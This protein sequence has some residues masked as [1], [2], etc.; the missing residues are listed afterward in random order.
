MS[1]PG[2]CTTMLTL[3]FV[4]STSVGFSDDSGSVL[5]L[6]LIL[7]RLRQRD[8][9]IEGEQI[10]HRAIHQH[11]GTVGLQRVKF[12]LGGIAIPTRI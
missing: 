3:P 5:S 12:G 9:G 7:L 10:L 8:A 2:R 11:V 1:G 6:G 4:D